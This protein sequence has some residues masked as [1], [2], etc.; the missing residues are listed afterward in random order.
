MYAVV[1]NCTAKKLPH[2]APA[3]ELYRGPSIRRVVSVIDGARKRGVVVELYVISAKHGLVHESEV[4]EPYDETIA[5]WPRERIKEWAR[6]GD[7][8]EKFQKLT[9]T[10]TVFLV[11][12]R[13][14]YFAVEDVVCEN[15]VYVLSRYQPNCGIWIKT[16]NFDKH[17][18]L[19]KLL[20]ERI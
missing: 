5:N 4:L 10:R 12:T 2:A 15:N 14:Y 20:T 16:G 17:I 6:E 13:P 19:R 18:E 1:A 8:L 7:L 11:V 9:A 3:R